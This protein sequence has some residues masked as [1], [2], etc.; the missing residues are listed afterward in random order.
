M[1]TVLYIIWFLIPL[2]FFL[3]AL[4]SSLERVGG[5]EGKPSGGDYFRQ[6]L[7]VSACV[8]VSVLI[9]Q[10]VLPG[11][12]ESIAPDYLP[13][14]FFQAILLPAVFYAAA[15]LFGGSKE[16]LIAKAPKPTQAKKRK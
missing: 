6:A 5:G 13:L 12:V 3:M 10:T 11:I 15:L 1:Q 16:I 14:G 7:F 2:A 8:A 9:D 4:W